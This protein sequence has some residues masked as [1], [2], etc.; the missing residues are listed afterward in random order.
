MSI[1]FVVTSI[2]FSS[3]K[4]MGSFMIPAYFPYGN[5]PGDVSTGLTNDQRLH[6]VLEDLTTY[7]QHPRQ[8]THMCPMWSPYVLA[9]GAHM[10]IPC[11]ARMGSA[12]GLRVG[13]MLAVSGIPYVPHTDPIRSPYG[14]HTFPI[15]SPY[16]SHTFP[17]WT[18]YIPQG[19]IPDKKVLTASHLECFDLIFSTLAHNK[20]KLILN[21]RCVENESHNICI[22]YVFHTRCS[23][24]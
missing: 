10:G 13:P 19:N 20:T 6:A 22:A 9:Y 11:G 17:I 14:S 18:P 7:T 3:Q 15:H 12:N 1:V 21:K 24:G 16:G 2:G 5:H 23:L 8:H 4:H